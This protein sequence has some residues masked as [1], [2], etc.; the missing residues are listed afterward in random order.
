MLQVT[1][2]N[3]EICPSGGPMTRE[4]FSPAR[5]AIFFFLTSFNRGRGPGPPVPSPLDP[6]LDDLDGP[7]DQYGPFS[8]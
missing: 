4:T 6:L 7:S 5:L 2:A 1:V 3:P 8:Q